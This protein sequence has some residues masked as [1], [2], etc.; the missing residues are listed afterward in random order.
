MI[1][2]PSFAQD[3]EEAEGDDPIIVT[4]SRI[5]RPEQDS[6]S[7]VTAI[8]AEE[9]DNTGIVRVEDLVNNLPQTVAAQTAFVSN[10]ASGTATLNLRGLGTLRTL[11]LMDGRR[12]PQGD[13]FATASDINQIPAQ[14]IKRIEVVTGGAST[15]YGADAVSGV[16]NFIMDR[17]FEG[18]KLDA[19]VNFYQHDNGNDSLRDL[20]DRSNGVT[21]AGGSQVEGF[22]YDINAAF[23]AS[24]DDGRGRVTAYAG[25]R[26]IEAILQSDYDTSACS[27]NFSATDPSGFT[28]AGSSTIPEGRFFQLPNFNSFTLKDSPSGDTLRPYN[29]ATDTY[30]YAPTNY[31]QRPD[32]RYTAGF[33]AEYEISEGLKPYAEFQYMD[34]RSVAQIAFSGTFFATLETISCGNPLL[35]DQFATTF[36]CADTT[37]ASPET[38][39]TYIGKR[40]VEGDPRQNDLRHTSYRA[41][42]GVKGNLSDNWSYDVYGLRGNTIYQ[43]TYLNDLSTSRITQALDVVQTPN[44]PQCRNQANGCVPLNVFQLGGVNRQAFD[45]ITIPG[46]QNADLETFVVSGYVSGL[47]GNPLGA[48]DIGVVLGAEYRKEQYALRVDQNFSEGT[49]AGQG[50]PTAPVSGDFA[51][52]EIFGEID[53]P[54][55][56][57]GIV[58]SFSINAGYRLSDYTSSG[59]SHTYKIGAILAPVAGIKIRGVYNRAVRAPN[60]VELFSPQSLGLFGGTDPC[61][62]TNVGDAPTGDRAGCLASGVTAAQYDGGLIVSNPAGQ[63]NQLGGGNPNLDVEKSDSWTVGVAVDGTQL[64]LTGFSAQVD[65]FNIELSGAIAGVGG[66]TALD[67]C[68]G[69]ADPTG[70]FCQLINRAPGSGSLW[71]GQAGFITNTQQNLG[72][73]KTSGIDLGLGYDYAL[74]DGSIYLDYAGTYTINNEFATLPPGTAGGGVAATF[75]DTVGYFGAT[76]GSPQPKYRHRVRAGYRA[77][78]GWSVNLGWRYFGGVEVDCLSADFTCGSQGDDRDSISAFSWFDLS[79]SVD[80]S[81]NF[82]FGLGV[83]NLLDKDPPIIGGAYNP[84]NG[85]T[86]AGQYDPVGRQFFLRGSMKF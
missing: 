43:N 5:A 17:E 64:G 83:N 56:S 29:G 57:D 75:R 50:G 55:I 71:L 65:Y 26:Q 84:G 49:L 85:N 78:G 74:N 25:Y 11:V 27:V 35:S 22:T 40:M 81:D 37:D 13:P 79:A 44:G 62:V 47:L 86:Y 7:P 52:R 80:V 4:G 3:A 14:L 76:A 10:G 36:G 73:L 60:V 63:Y 30:N 69:S 12:L 39:Q 32:K 24:F 15:V 46:L 59:T 9:I 33:F 82:T 54:L 70:Q 72:G 53:I 42:V 68:I 20:H 77:A 45:F 21:R 66:Q 1:S 34:D 31:F 48:D 58:D 41:V 23:G 51:V 61:A 6:V 8:G 18:F 19:G 67:L 38:F 28:C 2:T 16:V